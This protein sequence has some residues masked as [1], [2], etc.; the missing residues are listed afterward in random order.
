MKI[1]SIL[2][3]MASLLVLTACSTLAER[4]AEEHT[5]KKQQ[6]AEE[7]TAKEQQIRKERAAKIHAEHVKKQAKKAQE[8]T[9]RDAENEQ[10]ELEWQQE[11][12]ALL[13]RYKESLKRD[14]GYVQCRVVYNIRLV[15]G[16]TEQDKEYVAAYLRRNHLTKRD[17]DV[18]LNNSWGTPAIGLSGIAM[19][20]M[21]YRIVNSS[22]YAGSKQR[23]QMNKGSTYVYLTGD[24]TDTGMFVDGWN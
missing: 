6:I 10:I 8:K 9:K 19:K 3:M 12:A 7:N 21:G 17:T 5:A 15:E 4:L 2:I 1:K 13:V 23:W 14:T 24:G 11:Q 18:I 22:Y 16:Y 20:C